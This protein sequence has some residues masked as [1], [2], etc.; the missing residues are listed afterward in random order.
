MIVAVFSD[1]HGNLPALETFLSA[2]RGVADRYLCLGDIVNYGPWNDE[3][4]LRILDLPGVE[5]VAGNHDQL[6][7]YGNGVG[8]LAPLVQ[9]FFKAS[10]AFFSYPDLLKALPTEA[11]LVSFRCQHTI[12]ERRIFADTEVHIDSN[13]LIGH[14]HWP[15]EVDRGGW[16]LI[17]PGSV[18][19]NRERIDTIDFSLFDTESEENTP[20]RLP[21]DV[22][23]LLS[24]LRRRN[25]P[26]AC[27]DYYVKKLDECRNL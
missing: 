17:N 19:Q 14:S 4:L 20:I 12:N 2:T 9:E 8:E 13:Y 1:V 22:E 23:E 16:R 26:T 24:E 25:W 6:F 5:V 11:R 21:Y 15:Y 10:R 3:C 27:V 18:G 7:A